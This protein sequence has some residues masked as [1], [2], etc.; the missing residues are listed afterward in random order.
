MQQEQLNQVYAEIGFR[1]RQYRY[2]RGLNQRELAEKCG[3]EASNL[4]RI[5]LGRTNP[6]IKSLCLV[7]NGLEIPLHRLIDDLY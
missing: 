5:E 4:N 3:M 2:T 1:V 6:T 7:A